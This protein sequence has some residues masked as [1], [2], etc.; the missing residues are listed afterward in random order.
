MDLNIE[1]K[2]TTST[3]DRKDE[4]HHLH[5]EG[6]GVK[7]LLEDLGEKKLVAKIIKNVI[8]VVIVDNLN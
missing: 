7:N 4:S 6:D 1:E 5:V 2:S 3:D 8:L